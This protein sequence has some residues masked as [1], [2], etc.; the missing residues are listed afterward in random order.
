MLKLTTVFVAL[1]AVIGLVNAEKSRLPTQNHNFA[2][3]K[4]SSGNEYSVELKGQH[5]T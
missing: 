2:V 1:V 4:L 5:L 3:H